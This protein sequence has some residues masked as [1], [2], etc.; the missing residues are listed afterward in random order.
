MAKLVVH[1]QSGN[2]WEIQLKPGQNLL[3]RGF[4][5][6]FK[7]DDPSVSGSHCQIMVDLSGVLIKDLGSTNGTFVNRAQVREAPLLPGQ[8]VH[9]GEVEMVFQSEAPAVVRLP[10]DPAEAAAPAA[11][12]ARPVQV[13]MT[14]QPAGVR[15]PPAEAP[16]PVSAA[17]PA[18]DES[19]VPPP[20][21]PNLAV[22]AQYCKFHPKTPARYF[23]KKCNRFFCELCVTARGLNRT[24]RQCGSPAM[25]VEV[26]IARPVNK[27]FFSRIPE[28]FVY[29]FKG[30]G[31]VVMLITAAFLGGLNYLGGTGIMRGPYGWLMWVIGLGFLFLYMQNII[32]TTTS[33]ENEPL[34]FPN[35]G[36]IF[37]AAFELVVTVGVSFGPVIGLL[38]AKFFDADIPWALILGALLFGCLYFPMAFLA[39]AMK[40]SV[41]AANPLV[42]IPAI[43]K[44][45]IEYLV[46]AF[47]LMSVFAAR[48]GGA[49]MSGA[50]GAVT[51]STRS[52]N[53]LFIALALQ[54]IWSLVS[55]Y[56]L[57]VNM[58]ILAMLYVSKKEKFGW[59]RH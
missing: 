28:A 50:A 55:I 31:V 45:P 23:C 47:L 53:S 9:L 15:R 32:H 22:G 5:N 49:L 52:M 37:G 21:L 7:I 51:M 11:A 39:V 16:P 54:A 42:V 17:E 34:G 20:P 6:D 59:F 26:K 18:V 24:C 12:P 56:L 25:P 1:P 44:M 36:E 40:D 58:R 2:P 29:P 43:L 41:M 33:D 30:F 8:T 4:A 48:Q 46:T 35:A 27:G 57:S 38:I 19:L 13:R 10:D 3:G 14:L